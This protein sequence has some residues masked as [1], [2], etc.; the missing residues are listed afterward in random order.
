MEIAG[1]KGMKYGRCH[2][3]ISISGARQTQS[4]LFFFQCRCRITS[5]EKSPKKKSPAEK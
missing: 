5:E 2:V 4:D 1:E 3:Q